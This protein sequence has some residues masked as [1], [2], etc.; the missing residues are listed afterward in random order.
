MTSRIEGFRL[1][2]RVRPGERPWPSLR[3]VA[4]ATIIAIAIAVYVINPI[5][6]Q[7]I[8][9]VFRHIDWVSYSRAAQRFLDG[10]SIYAPE[11]LTGPYEMAR[12]AG[13]GYVYPP[14]S[15]LLFVP[16][17]ALGPTLW[18]VANA[19]LFASGLAAMARVAFG[20]Y[21]GLAFGIALLAAGLTTPYLDA[22]VMGNINLALAGLF[23]WTWALGRG[24]KSLGWLAAAGGLVKLHPFALAGWARP[25]DARRTIG[26]AI[27]VAVVVVLVT[28]PLVGI[29]SWID[30]ERA[31]TNARPLCGYGLDAVACRLIPVIGG[32]ATPALLVVAGLL[33]LAAIRVEIDVLSFSL[34]VVAVL[35]AHPEIFGHTLLLVEVLLFALAC[36]AA[37]WRWGRAG[38]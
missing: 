12:I 23:A 7:R 26:T 16:F 11:Q 13:L 17:L 38:G 21:A 9:E 24:S 1:G 35:I 19:I 31:A 14:P 22:M 15:I 33:V 5:L 36:A 37:R 10:Q 28:L 29:S 4:S 25:R 2:D 30:Y 32:L 34:I 27:F 3:V 18:A 6:D 8:P 20:R